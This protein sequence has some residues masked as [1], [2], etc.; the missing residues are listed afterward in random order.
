MKA[1]ISMCMIVKNEPFLE[2][3]IQSFR[4]YV[5]E[6]VIVDTGSTDNTPQV[7][8]KYADVFAVYT[9]CNDP[10][11]GMIEDFSKARNHSLSLATNKRVMWCDADDIIT[12]ME[13][14][15][16]FL[17]KCDNIYIPNHV[18][19]YSIMLPYEYAYDAN[20]KCTCRHYRERIFS[21]KDLFRF[22]NPVHEVAVPQDGTRLAFANS[23]DFVYKHQRQY[24]SKPADPQRNLRI[25]KK[26]VAG[27]GAN[28]PRQLYYIG[29]EYHNNGHVGEAIEV[30]TK[31]ID[32]SGWD[33]ERVMACLKLVDIYQAMAQYKEALKWAFKSIE[34]CEGWSEGYLAAG[35]MF[36]FLAQ[37][38][39]REQQRNWQ[40]CIHFI[41]AGLALPP[42]KTLLFINPVE[43]EVEIFK[44][45][46]MACNAVGDVQGALDAVN[47]GLRNQADP[48]LLF[49]KK[50]YENHL[51]IYQIGVSAETLRNNGQFDQSVVDLI[52]SLANN[53]KSVSAVKQEIP[54]PVSNGKYDIVFFI[55][56]GVESWTP[57][58]VKHS[59]IGGSEM[60]AIEMTKRL[61]G[62]GHRVRVY[63]GCGVAGEGIYDGVEY[64][65]TE[66]Y[67]HLQC[68]VL[69]VSRWAPAVADQFDVQA[70]LKLLW[71]H[72]VC[73]NGASPELLNKYDKL[74]ALSQ[75]HKQNIMIAHG[76]TEDRVVVTRNGID[77]KRF[78]KQVERNR[79]KVVN[80][81]S[82]DRYLA[83]LLDCWMAIKTR[84]PQATLDVFYGFKNWEFAAQH[85]P[86]QV[87]LINRLKAQM[88]L[89]KPVGVTFRDRVSQ[90]K[91]AEEFL[92]A[93]VWAYP[94][95][96]SESSCISAMEAQAAGLRI[97]TSSIAALNET[98]G[99]RDILIDGDWTSPEYQAKFVDAV[100]NALQR[101][102]D[103]DR[104]VLQE[105]AKNFDLDTLAQEW[106]KMFSDL[107]NQ[108][109]SPIVSDDILVPYSAF[110]G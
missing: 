34:I 58:T 50:L 33:D 91:L 54:A 14:M 88:T 42:T 109:N 51:A 76:L 85:D 44:Y 96:F 102:D 47:E 71:V 38:G 2:T 87:D 29:L 61:A 35:R 62:L 37:N 86:A 90:E 8:K 55:G 81:S 27:A 10:Q 23:D 65:Q 20:G 43:R 80:S 7:A 59:G 24:G 36:Y 66:K 70:K 17:D 49:N 107:I 32:V 74:L 30:L 105:Y 84:V 25:L 9:D 78:A 31:Y 110:R 64:L 13:G 89:M 48:S 4:E 75:W 56:P 60:M 69:V 100:V 63:T 93:G 103:S 40:R 28:D 104:V 94:T 72:D 73:A 83:V 1:K 12:G 82:P 19:C 15:S 41:K 106:E 98:V 21:N 92:S 6:L 57:E 95:W 39:G 52:L 16:K 26:Y 53:R 3:C 45:L 67:Q 68:D 97:V 101:E 22:V 46:N 77:L 99:T 79:F 11:T 18:D 108:T 5:E